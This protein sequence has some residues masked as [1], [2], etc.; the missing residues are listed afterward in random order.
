MDERSIL[1]HVLIATWF[2][3]FL[4][5]QSTTAASA[6]SVLCIPHERDAL[7][8]FRVGGLDDPDDYLSSWQGEDCCHW[9]GIRC[10]NRTG[11]VVELRLR[12]LEDVRS[13]IR[14][15]GGNQRSSPLLDLKNL[16]TLD[17]RV[18]NFDGAPIPE[19]IGGLKS[20]RYLYISGSKFGGRVRPQLGNLSML[21][22]LDLNSSGVHDSYIYSTDLSW[23][24]RLTTLEYLDLSNVNLSAA[25]D[26][27]HVVN[28]LPSLVTL[29][30]R[31]CGLQNVIPSPVNVNLTSLE[32]LDLYALLLEQTTYFGVYLVFFNLTWVCVASKVQF[33][34]RWET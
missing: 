20:L 31:F 9:K 7:L 21:L 26:W 19:F 23:L 18:N 11:H 25:T 16:R 5:I 15:R 33:Q 27:A 12:S 14:F 17:L 4:Q 29:N 28:K 8:A 10:S 6:R 22:Y 32:Y 24:P 30:L 34:K 1:V 13:S 2:L 3:V